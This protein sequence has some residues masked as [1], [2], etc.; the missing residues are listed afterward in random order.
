MLN[1]KNTAEAR[2]GASGAK[3]GAIS[4]ETRASDGVA[5]GRKVFLSVKVESVAALALGT[6]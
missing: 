5:S 2:P 1:A 3:Q 4:T 6:I